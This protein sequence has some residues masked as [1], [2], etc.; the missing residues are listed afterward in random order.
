MLLRLVQGMDGRRFENAVVSL[1]GTGPIGECLEHCGVRVKSMGMER[2]SMNPAGAL[3][4]LRHLRSERPD[5]I[6]TWMYHSDLLGGWCGRLATDAAVIWNIR[7]SN[8]ESGKN[9]ATTLLTAR[10]CAF[11]SCFIPWRIVCG[12]RA[13]MAEHTRI[14]YA[15]SRMILIPN[16]FDT[17]R[18]RPDNVVRLRIRRELGVGAQSILIGLV[19]RFDPLKDHS[20][21]FAAAADLLRSHP[22]VKFVLCGEGMNADNPHLA[23]QIRDERITP[24]L[25]LVGRRDDIPQITAA[26]DI[27]TLSSSGEG[28]PNV[29]GESMACGV[30]V[31]STDVGDAAWIVGGTGIVVPRQDPSALAAGWRTLIEAGEPERLRMGAA[32]RSRIENEFALQGTIQRYQMLY[33]E[34]AERVRHRRTH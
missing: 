29:L 5:V 18:F 16:G 20:T 22:D 21:F 7:H 6:Q 24:S 15:S 1:T 27:G 14:G 19:A 13:A 3:R 28:F 31:V 4:L 32:A 23:E 2:G 11:S 17:E 12:S 34:I 26:F 25:M 8:L 9:R 33:E 30:P 10:A